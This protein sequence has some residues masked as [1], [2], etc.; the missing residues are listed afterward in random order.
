EEEA[1]RGEDRTI[2]W[3]L[4]AIAA[5]YLVSALTKLIH[6]SGEWIL[7]S[8][9]I[10]VQIIKTNDQNYYDTLNPALAGTGHALAEWMA[11]HPLL[12]GVLL[13]SG[14]LIELTSPLLLLGRGWATFYGI[15]LLAFHQTVDRVM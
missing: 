13:T 7:Q 5:T 14:L 15:A 12:V 9:L 11:H 8:P 10:V 4:Q 3:S 6:T 2:Q 1:A